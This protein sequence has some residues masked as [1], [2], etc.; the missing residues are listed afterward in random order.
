M[1]NYKKILMLFAILGVTLLLTSCGK[2]PDTTPEFHFHDVN[3][4][5]LVVEALDDK[6][7][8]ESLKIYEIQA[9]G[10]V[11]EIK[12]NKA[13]TITYYNENKEVVN[14]VNQAVKKVYSYTF[15]NTA[16]KEVILEVTQYLKGS[17]LSEESVYI[18]YIDFNEKGKIVRNGAVL[19]NS[20][21]FD[22]KDLEFYEISSEGVEVIDVENIEFTG[23]PV[24]D[25][26]IVN[27]KYIN[28][29]TFPIE[30]KSGKLKAEFNIRLSAVGKPIHYKTASFWN[31]VTLKMPI[32]YAM[33]FFGN[34]TGKSFALAI[35]LTT[36]LV[37]TLAW[38][39]YAKTNDMSLKMQ[40]AQPDLDKLQR[41]YATRKDPESQQKMQMEMMAI[42]KK[43]KINFLG[44]LLPILQMP[45]FIAMYQVVNEITVP[46][47]Q[48]YSSVANTQFFLTDLAAGGAISKIIFTALVGLT[49][50]GLQK[51][52]SMKPSYAKSSPTTNTDPKANQQA[53]TMKMVS[54]MMI[55]MMMMTSY[56][57]PGLALSYYWIIGNLYSLGQTLFN[58]YV[59]EKKYHKAEEERLYGRSREIIDAQFKEKGDK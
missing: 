25:D 41:K 38:P 10:Q 35:L 32:A 3:S 39:I 36:I 34:I 50:W 5:Q 7:N 47:G 8:I 30:L 43:H 44:C 18:D 42:Y 19:S 57:A 14:S 49:M 40:L 29:E 37:R 11:V 45:I 6:E 48:F 55:M 2:K 27:K 58:R 17:L 13:H 28:N 1:K 24:G 26:L 4:E 21:I 56:F 16:K 53:Q 33:S 12:V 52:S 22:G 31:W 23:F 59:S 51:I 46:G 20:Y 15:D 54:F 9:A